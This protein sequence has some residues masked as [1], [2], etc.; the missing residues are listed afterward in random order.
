MSEI[1]IQAK[2]RELSTKGA[3][4]K[5][6]RN[7]EIPGIYYTKGTEPI[8]ISV[9]ELSLNPIVY[10]S[11]AHIIDLQLGDNEVKKSILKNIQF[12]PV[13]DKIVH[14]D[15]L[16]I[17]LDKEIDIEV[18][19]AIEGQPKGIKD[20]GIIQQSMYKLHVLCLPG[21]I[22]EHITINISDLGVG[23]AVHVKDLS[24]ERVKFLHNEEVIIVAV[25]MPRA[26][27]EA[28]VAVAETLG[29]EKVEPE[30][31]SKGKQVEDEE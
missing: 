28:P 4:N 13:T 14:F 25:V 17:S 6:R 27:V 31:I 1:T 29:E 11:E 12:D 8:P 22:P 10:T 26:Q 15:L 23:D 21:D 30:V 2:K 19:I 9:Q 20:G 3:V 18:P 24:I 5:L 16:G 7:G